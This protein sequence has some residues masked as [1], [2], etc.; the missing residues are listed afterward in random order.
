MHHHRS[1]A[2]A[3]LILALAAGP[4]ACAL[5]ARATGSVDEASVALTVQAVLAAQATAVPPT[6]VPPT[7]PPPTI[8]ISVTPTLTP[9]STPTP[10]QTPIPIPCDAAQFVT[11]VTI[12]DNSSVTVNTEFT[13]TWRLRNSGTCTWTSGYQLVFDHGDR[14]SAPEAAMLTSGTVPPGSTLDVSVTLKAPADA[15]TYQGF[16]KLRNPS[17]V[18]FGIGADG[19]T[20]FWVKIK[21]ET[22]LLLVPIPM[23]PIVPLVPHHL[24]LGDRHGSDDERLLQSRYRGGRRLRERRVRLPIRLRTAEPGCDRSSQLGHVQR[25]LQLRADL[26]RLP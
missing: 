22:F 21:A 7:E 11:D 13:K 23:I 19:N 18:L 25:A 15:G 5:P 2:L 24:L 8:E 20:A 9:T 3:V 16:F 4:L 12:A 1:F 14:M 10:T 26:L 17:G 6:A